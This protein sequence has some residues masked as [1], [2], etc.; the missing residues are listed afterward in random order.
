M[1]HRGN[2]RPAKK[3]LDA[4]QQL[5]MVDVRTPCRSRS[6]PPALTPPAMGLAL[7]SWCAGLRPR[8]RRCVRSSS[9]ASCPSR[10]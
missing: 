5:R 9:R 1:K 10:S 4:T 2:T 6:A 3:Q 7:R 8:A